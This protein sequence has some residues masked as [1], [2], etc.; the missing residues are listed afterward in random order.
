MCCHEI[1]AS[2][3]VSLA[4]K[5]PK[6]KGITPTLRKIPTS[7]PRRRFLTGE[8]SSGATALGTAVGKWKSGVWFWSLACLVAQNS[9]FSSNCRHV[10]HVMS[11]IYI[12]QVYWLCLLDFGYQAYTFFYFGYNQRHPLSGKR[13]KSSSNQSLRQLLKVEFVGSFAEDWTPEWY[14]VVFVSGEVKWKL[15]FQKTLT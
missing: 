13:G 3:T 1:R 5:Y 10:K 11:Y 6:Q 9:T 15:R 14:S 8:F 2:K 12:C 7:R 4:F